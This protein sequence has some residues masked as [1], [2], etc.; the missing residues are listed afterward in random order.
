MQLAQANTALATQLAAAGE[1]MRRLEADNARLRDAGAALAVDNEAL[2]A[3]ARGARADASE[4]AADRAWLQAELGASASAAQQL[5]VRCGAVRRLVRVGVGC[6]HA[7]C[8]ARGGVAP[9]A[10]CW[11]C[12]CRRPAPACCHA[13]AAALLCV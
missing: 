13:V 10:C 6:R 12:W 5:Q 11:G 1:T 7:S 4:L 2:G 8:G 9:Y 3:E